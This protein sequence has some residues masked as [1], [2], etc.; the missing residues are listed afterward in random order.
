[1]DRSPSL[2]SLRT[3]RGKM[4]ADRRAGM[5]LTELM[6][7]VS[8]V[9]VLSAW[10]GFGYLRTSRQEANLRREAFVRTELVRDLE[11][12]ERGLS[13]S[14]GCTNFETFAFGYPVETAGVSFETNR[15]HHVKGT[16]VTPP[17]SRMSGAVR[18]KVVGTVD[19]KSA[20]PGGTRRVLGAE[21]ASIFDPSLISPKAAESGGGGRATGIAECTI[22]PWFGNSNL[23]QVTL[24]APVP[25]LRPDGTWTERTVR[26]D[27]VVRM[28]NRQ[29]Q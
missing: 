29:S 16:T 5:T 12:L 11:R 6:V 10:V 28:W 18:G 15:F 20:V 8:I 25:W 9:V 14:S 1:M 22:E 3:E 2:E 13:L 21:A 24:S 27:R 26:V 23:L 7:V 17:D 4:P 19:G